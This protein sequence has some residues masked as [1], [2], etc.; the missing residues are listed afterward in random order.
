MG[1]YRLLAFIIFMI[2][3]VSDLVVVEFYADMVGLR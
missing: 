3:V 1:R 2:L